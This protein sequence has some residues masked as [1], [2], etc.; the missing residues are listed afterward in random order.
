[1]VK[2]TTRCNALYKY[3]RDLCSQLF[4]KL[5]NVKDNQNRSRKS[6]IRTPALSSQ[7]VHFCRLI[8]DS[9][10]EFSDIGIRWMMV[11]VDP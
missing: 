2:T 3:S 11:K 1:M 8:Q 5:L 9:R 6:L 7:T 10:L 4:S